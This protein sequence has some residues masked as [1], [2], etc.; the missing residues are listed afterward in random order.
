MR[1]IATDVPVAVYVGTPTSCA[2]T[3][4]GPEVI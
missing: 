2:E 1:P 3:A 4:A